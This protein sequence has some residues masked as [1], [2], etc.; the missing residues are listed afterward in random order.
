MKVFSTCV[1]VIAI[2]A[3]VSAS[4]SAYKLPFGIS[5]KGMAFLILGIL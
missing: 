4:A 2:L 5:T 3:V 1:V